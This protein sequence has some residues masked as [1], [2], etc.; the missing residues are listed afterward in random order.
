MDIQKLIDELNVEKEAHQKESD[1]MEASFNVGYYQG[2]ADQ[3][4]SFVNTLTLLL[5]SAHGSNHKDFAH[6]ANMVLGDSAAS[7]ETYTGEE[8]A[9][10]SLSETVIVRQN[11]VAKEV[12]TCGNVEMT[13]NEDGFE[14]CDIC[15]KVVC[16]P[17]DTARRAE[18]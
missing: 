3:C 17:V 1:R 2:R 9:G 8:P 14:R 13:Y 10:E 18:G 12:C 16:K 6:C 15:E 7:V 5:K 11:E 4:A